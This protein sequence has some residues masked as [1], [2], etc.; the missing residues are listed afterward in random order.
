MS[1]DPTLLR[2]TENVREKRIPFFRKA[3]ENVVVNHPDVGNAMCQLVILFLQTDS[4]WR[5][6]RQLTRSIL[7]KA[8]LNVCSCFVPY[9]GARTNYAAYL[10]QMFEIN[11]K[12]MMTDDLD[13]VVKKRMLTINTYIFGFNIVKRNIAPIRTSA[14]ENVSSNI[15]QFLLSTGLVSVDM[16]QGFASKMRSCKEEAGCV[17]IMTDFMNE[18]QNSGEGSSV[19]C[20]C[21]RRRFERHGEAEQDD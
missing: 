12:K 18:M 4:E 7:L 20:A 16:Y 6:W 19:L 8:T 14:K 10:D 1:K 5:W 2:D 15:D 3:F 11:T 13:E 9:I 21:V 17:E